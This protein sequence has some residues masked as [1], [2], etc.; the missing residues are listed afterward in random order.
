MLKSLFARGA[1]TGQRPSMAGELLQS[2][3]FSLAST[4]E[5]HS[6][7]GAATGWRPSTVGELLQPEIFSPAGM[8]ESLSAQGAAI[9]RGP[10]T[11]GVLLQ[12]EIFCGLSTAIAGDF[13]ARKEC[14]R[15]SLPGELH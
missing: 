2:E 9:G 12:S 4:P 8:P 6:A 15:A 5:S 7:W 11:V 13:S 3:I 14:Q 10:S 1:T